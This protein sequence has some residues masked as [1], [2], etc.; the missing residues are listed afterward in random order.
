[1]FFR[2]G[3]YWVGPPHGCSGPIGECRE[4]IAGP[5]IK[6]SWRYDTTISK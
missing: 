5:I 1:M 6:F 3:L 4:R 2:D